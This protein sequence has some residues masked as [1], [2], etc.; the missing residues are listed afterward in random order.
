M[1]K[2]R[3]VWENYKLQPADTIFVRKSH[4]IKKCSKTSKLSKDIFNVSV[5]K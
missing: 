3:I 1:H 2:N 5:F 4:S